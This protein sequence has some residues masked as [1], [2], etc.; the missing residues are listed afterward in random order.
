MVHDVETMEGSNLQ[1]DFAE[2]VHAHLHARQVDARLH[3]V[4]SLWL[5]GQ[6]GISFLIL[7]GMGLDVHLI[8]LHSYPRVVV[9][10]PLDSNQDTLHGGPAAQSM[11]CFSAG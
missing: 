1:S 11:A 5:P 9:H 8:R 10:H 2:R 6:L 7:R 3:P 4:P